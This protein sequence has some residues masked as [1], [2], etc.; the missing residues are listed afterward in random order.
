MRKYRI[1]EAFR[2]YYIEASDSGDKWVD[3]YL[4]IPKVPRFFDSLADARSW[5]AT[6]KRGVVYHD[7]EDAP[8]LAQDERKVETYMT[9]HGK[10]FT[11]NEIEWIESRPIR[12]PHIIK[13]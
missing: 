6:I 9:A 1:A 5:V 11:P 10:G 4:L 2:Q 8:N 13:P 7:A 3:A 12:N